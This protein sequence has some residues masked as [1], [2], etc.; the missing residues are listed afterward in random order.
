MSIIKIFT[1]KEEFRRI[2]RDYANT[3]YVPRNSK[4]CYQLDWLVSL[5]SFGTDLHDYWLEFSP[6]DESNEWRMSQLIFIE[7]MLFCMT[8]SVIQQR[9][10][11]RYKNT[12]LFY[13]LMF[14][15]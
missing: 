13:K 10:K 6:R 2:Y 14:E 5:Y 7:R 4:N 15:G 1:P 11:T 8:P 12:D 3:Y 9:Y